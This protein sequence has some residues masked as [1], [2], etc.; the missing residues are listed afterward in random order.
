MLHLTRTRLAK[1]ARCSICVDISHYGMSFHYVFSLRLLSF[2]LEHQSLSFTMVALESI[3]AVAL[4]ILGLAHGAAVVG[5][6]SIQSSEICYT[7]L[8]RQ[9]VKHV[10]TSSSTT[11]RT[12]GG[13]PRLTAQFS[14]SQF[15]Q[16]RPWCIMFSRQQ[17]L[18]LPS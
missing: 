14:K 8:G 9:P 10:S 6:R 4:S 18:Y 17:L 1:A 16:L 11:T 12:V 2:P 7:T 5:K 15:R 13:N 3:F